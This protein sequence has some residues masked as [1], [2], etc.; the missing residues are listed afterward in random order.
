MA[1]V[2]VITLLVLQGT[3]AFL[4]R[5][6]P[7]TVLSPSTVLYKKTGK[8]SPTG[9]SKGFGSSA[10]TKSKETSRF[11][12]AGEIRPGK[13]SPQ[14][15]VVEESILQPDYAK[16]G[17]PKGNTKLALPWMIEVKKAEEIEKMRASGKLAR[18]ILDLAG[19]AVK[20]GV[21]TDEIDAIVHEAI[22]E[23]GHSSL[24]VKS[25]HYTFQSISHNRKNI[26]RPEPIQVR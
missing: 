8:R 17:T 15:I 22:V 21:T 20:P 19:R 7:S 2:L 14:R 16:T 18:E 10:T 25:Y 3:T 12:Y 26:D 9:G 24:I 1:S 4:Q 13:Q 23:V 6:I 11:P 5:S